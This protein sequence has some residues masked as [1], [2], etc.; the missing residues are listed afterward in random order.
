MGHWFESSR[1]SH[2][3]EEVTEK[4][5]T[6]F[7]L[8]ITPRS[9]SRSRKFPAKCSQQAQSIFFGERENLFSGTDFYVAGAVWQGGIATLPMMQW[10]RC[11]GCFPHLPSEARTDGVCTLLTPL[12]IGCVMRWSLSLSKAEWT[13]VSGAPVPPVNR[14]RCGCATAIAHNATL[15]K[16]GERVE[17]VPVELVGCRYPPA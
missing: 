5:V 10:C 16:C 9:P 7:S 4:S 14:Y 11:G 3:K 6:S 1:G 17:F 2:T 8:R 13:V 15:C 12:Y